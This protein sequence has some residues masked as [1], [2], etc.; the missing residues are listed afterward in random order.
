MYVDC[1]FRIVP[2]PF[3]QCLIIMIFDTSL[4]IYVPVAWI[5]MTGK[6]DECYWQA[7]N[8]LTNAVP[9]M[10]PSFIGVDFEK[11]FFTQ[12]GIRSRLPV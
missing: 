4:Q 6:T 12:V 2:N 1:T 3:Y 11:A 8:W 5:L 9:R 7:F 10:D